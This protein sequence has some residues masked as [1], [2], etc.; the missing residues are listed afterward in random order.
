MHG[1][2]KDLRVMGFY[3]GGMATG[4]FKKS[5][6][7]YNDN[8]PWMFDPIESA[9]AMNLCSLPFFSFIYP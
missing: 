3:P 1:H 5:G 9:E 8:E 6:I 2:A 7:E 4:I